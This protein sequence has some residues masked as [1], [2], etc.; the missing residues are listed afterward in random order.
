MIHFLGC[1]G[2]DFEGLLE[3][4]QLLMTI[5]YILL[6]PEFQRY[7]QM[8]NLLSSGRI[9]FDRLS[10]FS[11]SLIEITNLHKRKDRY[12]GSFLQDQLKEKPERIDQNTA[13]TQ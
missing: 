6:N 2:V 9:Y 4:S 7:V 11:Y 10:I 5:A 1:G 12:S 3:L 8:M 13:F